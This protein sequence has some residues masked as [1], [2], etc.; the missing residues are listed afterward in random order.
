MHSTEAKAEAH[1]SMSQ[2]Y[3]GLNGKSFLFLT[4]GRVDPD[5]AELWT[6]SYLSLGAPPGH[7]VLLLSCLFHSLQ[8]FTSEVK[9][10]DQMG[11]VR[12]CYYSTD[13]VHF[14]SWSYLKDKVR[15]CLRYR[16]DIAKGDFRTMLSH[17]QSSLWHI[18]LTAHFFMLGTVTVEDVVVF[19]PV[20]YRGLAKHWTTASH[21]R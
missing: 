21:R 4:S 2:T 6:G 15:C 20:V 18:I 7:S 19:S 11:S 12:R 5:P 17:C 9:R 16:R 14:S 3:P 13:R 10:L 8:A 1:S